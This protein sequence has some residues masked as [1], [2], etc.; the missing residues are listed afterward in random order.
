MDL[1]SVEGEKGNTEVGLGFGGGGE[2]G[3]EMG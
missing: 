3:F 1:G 2:E